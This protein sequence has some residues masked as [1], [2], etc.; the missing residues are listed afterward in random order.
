MSCVDEQT[1]EKIAKRKALGRLGGLRRGVRI[2]RLR[3]GEDWLFGFLKMKFREEGFQVAVKFAYVDCK[4][5]AFEKIPPAVEEK[6]RRYLEDGLAALLEREL[7][8]AVRQ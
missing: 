6:V 7:G 2:I 5:A 8:N 3:V 4:G 1:A